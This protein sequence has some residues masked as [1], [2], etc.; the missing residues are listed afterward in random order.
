MTYLHLPVNLQTNWKNILLNI[1]HE[2]EAEEKINYILLNYEQELKNY[3]KFCE[4]TI[5]DYQAKNFQIKLK[6][7]FCNALDK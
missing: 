3:E 5:I 4:K 1:F 7:F 2:N 6:N